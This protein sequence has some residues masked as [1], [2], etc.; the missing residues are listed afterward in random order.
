MNKI[1]FMWIL[2]V[3]IDMML[4]LISMVCYARSKFIW[5]KMSQLTLRKTPCTKMMTEKKLSCPS[6]C[7][8]VPH[9]LPQGR[10]N[11]SV[12]E[13]LYYYTI[14]KYWLQFL[15]KPTINPSTHQI[16]YGSYSTH[17]ENM[18]MTL[19]SSWNHSHLQVPH[20]QS[21]YDKVKFI[22]LPSRIPVVL[23]IF[24]SKIHF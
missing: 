12:I 16:S 23:H 19:T 21:L 10:V 1:A 15:H 7:L 24:A 18:G 20:L 14:L 17:S 5:I 8:Y 2:V 6:Q 11:L 22:W 3:L 13:L 9:V 4:F